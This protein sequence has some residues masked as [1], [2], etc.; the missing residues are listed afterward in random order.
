VETSASSGDEASP[1]CRTLVI[2]GASGD[3][4]RRKLIPALYSL[5]RDGLLPPEL[6]IVGFSRTAPGNDDFRRGMR[7]AVREFSR[8][9]P[10]E[11]DWPRFALR[12][13]SLAGD[14]A[15]DADYAALQRFADGLCPR[16]GSGSCLYYLALPPAAAETVLGQLARL[17]RERPG[18]GDRVLIEKPFGS[19]LEGARRLNRLCAAGF[20]ESEIGRID[21]YLAKDTVRNLLVLRFGN[22]VFEELWNR[23][24]IDNIQITAA[25][26]LGVGSRAGY[27]EAAGVVRD[28]IQN[29]LLQIMALVAMEPPLPGDLDSVRTHRLEV[30]KSILPVG[31]EDFAFGQYRGYR[32]EPG[33]A[34][35][36]R[37]PTFAAL[38][39][40]V[41]NWRWQGVPFYLRSGK[42][43]GRRLSEV[44]IRFKSVPLCLLE[45]EQACQTARPNTLGIRLHP[46]EGLRLA[47]NVRLP[48]CE[49]RL[50]Q[51]ELDFRYSQLGVELPEAY[52]RVLLDA[53]RGAPLVFPRA[54][55]V[56]AAWQVVMPL[57]EAGARP[58]TPELPVYEPGSWG[59]AEAAALPARD[60][61]AWINPPDGPPK[62]GAA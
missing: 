57:V 4:T 31:P 23:R 56:E 44:V 33:V 19:D 39:L 20:G 59:P 21:H 2:F 28:M 15:R 51:T 22:A 43:L 36:S 17:R 27:Y 8:R 25:E 30:F 35:G 48:G 42:A 11:A 3:L 41:A 49:Q 37:T 18:P 54:D 6:R 40:E 50:E 53:L 1:A 16:G 58:G 9:P 7:E 24:H 62:P 52:E 12:L 13:H 45:S 61:R 32:A 14:Y 34:P 5:D 46:D 29:H 55:E 10:T 47:F 60:G 38:R 26:T